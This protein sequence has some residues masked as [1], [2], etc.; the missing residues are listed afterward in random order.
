MPVMDG[1][2]ATRGIRA[3]PAT[4]PNRA[5]PVIAMTA[6]AMQGDQEKCLAAGMDDYISKP[7]RSEMLVE[8]L[9]T[10]LQVAPHPDFAQARAAEE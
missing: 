10:W 5:I 9:H 7:I 1:L 6:E 8:R 3:L 2:E 4:N